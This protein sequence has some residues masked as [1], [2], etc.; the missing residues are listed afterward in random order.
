MFIGVVEQQRKVA[1]KITALGGRYELAV[2]G[3]FVSKV[4]L[5]DTEVT[6]EW[7]ANLHGLFLAFGGLCF[8]ELSLRGCRTVTDVGLARL[9]TTRPGLT[10]RLQTLDLEGTSISDVGLAR[11][12]G[13]K[14]LQSLSLGGTPTTD[15]GVR[16]LQMTLPTLK[17]SR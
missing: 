2:G 5:S 9:L 7:L 16:D 10:P 4:D 3:H 17:V 15:A 13:L 12:K 14:T 1:T 11:L 8:R 6:D